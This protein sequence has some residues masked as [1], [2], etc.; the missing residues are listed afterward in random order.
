VGGAAL[1]MIASA[2]FFGNALYQLEN[3]PGLGDEGCGPQSPE[4]STANPHT[5]AALEIGA[6]V[7]TAL[8]IGLIVFGLQQETD[9][10]GPEQRRTLA[11]EYNAH[12]AKSEAGGADA[13]APQETQHTSLLR[14]AKRA[15]LRTLRAIPIAADGARGLALGISF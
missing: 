13:D 6:A 1:G 7:G 4:P 14:A 5:T 2:L 9:E 8:G 3:C 15:Q 11:A 10:G 12:I